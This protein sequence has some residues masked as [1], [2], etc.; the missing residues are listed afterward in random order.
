MIPIAFLSSELQHRVW[1]TKMNFCKRQKQ[2]DLIL[3]RMKGQDVNAHKSKQEKYLQFTREKY[4]LNSKMT[5]YPLSFQH[6]TKRSKLY[7]HI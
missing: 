2:I 6:I 5:E 7:T 1:Y 3:L 4:F